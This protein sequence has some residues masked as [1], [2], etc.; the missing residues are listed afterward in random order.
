MDSF[1]NSPVV[2]K[3]ANASVPWATKYRTKGWVSLSVAQKRAA[4]AA[5]GVNPS[6]QA[7]TP[8]RVRVRQPPQPGNRNG[9]GT[10]GK[11][12]TVTKREYI[13]DVYKTEGA[14]P[15]FASWVINPRSVRSFPDASIC[16]M[17]Y[18]KYRVTNFRVHFS[19]TSSFE[20]NGMVAI[21][22]N[23]DSSDE[24]PTNK[25]QLSN[26][27]SVVYTSAKESKSITIPTDNVTRFLRDSTKDDAKLVDV[28]R[29]ILA[30][31]GFDSAAPAVV[32]ELHFEY[33]I[34]FSDP[35]FTTALTQIGTM[36]D[37]TGPTYARFV[38]TTTLTSVELLAPGRWLV[39][40]ANETSF[41]K[42]SINGPGASGTV[43]FGDT[44]AVC[45]V[46]NNLPGA[47]ISIAS[48]TTISGQRWFVSRL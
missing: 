5:M 14:T 13:S 29:I 18:N 23:S 43:E 26:L 6:M 8:Q 47:T 37:S 36:A 15:S 40:L 48:T 20:V 19:N 45:Q 28:G 1:K 33:T 7:V 12:H 32:G 39:V 38:S 30:T 21:G 9:P 2:I 31:Y 3:M 35:T 46:E 27:G 42:P 25:T 17:Q 16:A 10:A 34:V 24:V 22:F 44:L 41:N 11:S 4:R